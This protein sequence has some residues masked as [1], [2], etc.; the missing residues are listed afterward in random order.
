LL[1]IILRYSS[2]N[3]AKIE[4]IFFKT[5]NSLSEFKQL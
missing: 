5:A 1:N 4:A 3:I 2:V